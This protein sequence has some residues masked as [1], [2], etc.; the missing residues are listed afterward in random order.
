MKDVTKTLERLEA[1]EDRLEVRL[2]SLSALI[3]HG[4]LHV[5]GELHLK[6]GMQLQR[7]I[8]LDVAVYDSLS[9]VVATGQV[10]YL[11]ENFFGFEVFEIPVAVDELSFARICIYPKPL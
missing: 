6:S 9:R 3:E 8:R 11:A 10:V 1:F 2:E 4:Y 7:N 5:R